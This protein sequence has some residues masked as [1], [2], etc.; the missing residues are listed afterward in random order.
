MTWGG[1]CFTNTKIDFKLDLTMAGR[2]YHWLLS[3]EAAERL[4]KWGGGGGGHQQKRALSW[5]KKGTY[6]GKSQSENKQFLD[7]GIYP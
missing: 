4:S 6:K 3:P 7:I 2:S 1:G 5:E